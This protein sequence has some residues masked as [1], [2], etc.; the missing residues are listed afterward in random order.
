MARRAGRCAAACGIQTHANGLE[1]K[2]RTL[3]IATQS[4]EPPR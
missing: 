1:M 2:V 4:H 3:A